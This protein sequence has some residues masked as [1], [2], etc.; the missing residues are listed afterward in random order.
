MCVYDRCSFLDHG[1]YYTSLPTLLRNRGINAVDPM[2]FLISVVEF[3]PQRISA[4]LAEITPK[5]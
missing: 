3:T 1:N 2:S 4:E 5:S